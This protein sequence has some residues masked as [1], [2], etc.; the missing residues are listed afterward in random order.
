MEE[1]WAEL[2]VRYLEVDLHY[3]LHLPPIGHNLLGGPRPCEPF[4]VLHLVPPA[5]AVPAPA[6]DPAPPPPLAPQGVLGAVAGLALSASAAARS[7]SREALTSAASLCSSLG[8]LSGAVR[9]SRSAPMAGQ[10]SRTRSRVARG[11]PRAEW[12]ESMEMIVEG[13]GVD[14]EGNWFNATAPFNRL[15]VEVFHREWCVPSPSPHTHRPLSPSPHTH[16]TQTRGHEGT[17]P[18]PAPV[19]PYTCRTYARARMCRL[20]PDPPI[21]DPE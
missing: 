7:A 8:S 14:G 11:W 1:Q 20:P 5:E 2:E 13:G 12:N 10:Y 17:F 15:R 16:R 6:A 19:L 9:A 21:H 4:A 18:P 3:A